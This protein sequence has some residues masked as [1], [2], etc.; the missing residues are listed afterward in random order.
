M[1]HKMT[2]WIIKS[3]NQIS[4]KRSDLKSVFTGR[5]EVLA[6]VIFSQ[7]PVILLT[8]GEYLTRHTPPLDQAGTPPSSRYTPLAGT[9]PPRQVHPLQA[10]T[11]PK[12]GTPLQAGTPPFP[13]RYTPSRQV[14]PPPG[15]YP[16]SRQV[17]PLQAGTPP[18]RQVHPP[19]GRYTPPPGRYTPLQVGTP[20]SRQVHPP[21][22]ADPG[23]RST[24]GRYASY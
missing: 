3:C 8:G 23:I 21:E 24:I 19:P 1:H 4:L 20:P 16:P 14:H 2:Q 13:G 17:H 18:S 5:I 10:G 7:A 12:A 22:T 9:P 15:R 6:K 11:P